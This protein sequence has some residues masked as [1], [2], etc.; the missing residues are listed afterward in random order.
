VFILLALGNC[1]TFLEGGNVV[2]DLAAIGFFKGQ[3][4]G[5]EERKEK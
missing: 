1:L 3:Q 2:G 4:R 5:Q